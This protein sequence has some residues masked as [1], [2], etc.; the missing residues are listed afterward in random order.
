MSA[1]YVRTFVQV[2]PHAC[3][4]YEH[5]FPWSTPSPLARRAR[6][7]LTLAR[8]FLLLEDD[9]DVD[10]EVDRERPGRGAAR[11]RTDDRGRADERGRVNEPGRA[12]RRRH[13]AAPAHTE[14]SHPHRVWLRG[15]SSRR[16]PG[17]PRPVPQVCLCPVR[18]GS[19]GGSV[20]AAAAGRP[21][22]CPAL[23]T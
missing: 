17:A 18:S 10:W 23:R 15:R 3:L 22:E 5:M 8:S 6:N 9:Y 7:A 19:R 14:A 16:R 12:H 1:R 13:R 21:E 2:R 4:S 20:Q 11:G